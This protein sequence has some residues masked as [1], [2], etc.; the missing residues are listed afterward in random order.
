MALFVTNSNDVFG[1]YVEEAGQY[2]VKILPSSA[3]T[4]SQSSGKPMLTLNYEVLDGK[5]KGADIM[6]HNLVWDDSDDY[7]REMTIKRFNTFCAAIGVQDG[8]PINSLQQ[9]VSNAIGHTLSVD[10][11]WSEHQNGRWYLDVRGQHP[12]LKEGSQSNGQRRPEGN[13]NGDHA[14]N[15]IFQNQQSANA[16]QPQQQGDEVNN[17]PF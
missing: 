12:V 1:K 8:T 7:R 11:E 14:N 4:N 3:A 16:P 9:L 15:N 6:Y 10:T 5:Y 2:N 17:V 13:G